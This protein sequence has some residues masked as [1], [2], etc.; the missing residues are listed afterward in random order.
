MNSFN[1]YAY[2]AI[3]DWMYRKVAGLDMDPSAPAF[4]QLRIEPLF[5]STLLTHAEASYRSP[6]GLVKSGWSVNGTRI[7]VH[8][9]IPANTTGVIVLRG[10]SLSGVTLNGTKISA[11]EGILRVREIPDGLEIETGSGEYRFGY[12]NAHLFYET[13]SE[14]TRLCEALLDSRAVEVFRRRAPHLLERANVQIAKPLTFKQ[15]AENGM[16]KVSRETIDRILDDL[17]VTQALA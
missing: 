3:G 5:G 9:V 11:Q 7:D 8:A 4:K 13:Y 16:L 15:I 10:A 12:E 6:Y 2:G 17:T 14:D 1:H